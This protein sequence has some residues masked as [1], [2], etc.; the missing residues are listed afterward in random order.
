MNA[1]RGCTGRPC[2][3][4]GTTP[5]ASFRSFRRK[6]GGQAC[7]PSIE[8]SL[9]NPSA[10]SLAGGREAR[11]EARAF[12]QSVRS[13][14]PGPNKDQRAALHESTHTHHHVAKRTSIPQL[15][16]G[17]KKEEKRVQ[18][19]SARHRRSRGR[20]SVPA[21]GGP[22][23][24][25]APSTPTQEPHQLPK[26]VIQRVGAA[27]PRWRLGRM[28]TH[29]HCRGL[30]PSRGC[31]KLE[32][33]CCSASSA[34]RRLLT[35]ARRPEKTREDRSSAAEKAGERRADAARRGG[36]RAVFCRRVCA[37]Q[38]LVLLAPIPCADTFRSHLR[39]I[40]SIHRTR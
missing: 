27:D 36:R 17:K 2:A 18:C 31:F 32:H 37:K 12:L 29:H 25:H 11:R 34:I 38:S 19:S 23:T 13:A 9:R 21:R 10:I 4:E 40:R 5:K 3:F 22:C 39:H 15:L 28:R 24:L 20:P 26:V 16:G 35:S 8:S 33:I 1:A 7:T 6:G 30:T 14:C